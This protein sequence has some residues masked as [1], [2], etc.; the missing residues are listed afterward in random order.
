MRHLVVFRYLGREARAIEV[1][2]AG[3]AV[4]RAEQIHKQGAVDVMALEAKC[5]VR[6]GPTDKSTIDREETE[7]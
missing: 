6:W 7:E 4:E 2:T 3:K 5:L 1:D